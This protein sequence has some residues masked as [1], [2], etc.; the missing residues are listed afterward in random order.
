M[1][2]LQREQNLFGQG[3]SYE[4]FSTL[5]NRFPP[6]VQ[7]WARLGLQ[8]EYR[9]RSREVERLRKIPRY[10]RTNTDL[11]GARLEIPDAASFLVLHEDLIVREAYRFNATGTE[12][13]IIDGGANIGV[14]TIYFK[15]AHPKS[16]I[17]AFEPDP[18]IFQILD[19]NCRA[20]GL[21]GVELVQKALW[22]SEGS[23]DF[24][25]EGSDAGR[26]SRKSDI[27]EIISVPACRLR[28]YLNEEVEMLKLDIEGAETAVLQDC[29][30]LL[31]NVHHLFVEYHS[32]VDSPQTLT[33][34]FGLLR[35]AGFRVHVQSPM[36]SLQPFFRREA[37]L[38][39]DLQLNIFAFRTSHT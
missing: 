10:T 16:R 4:A 34:I 11:L 20:F 36:S 33:M 35:D 29:A 9:W 39:M 31:S 28:P 15:K 22:A 13:L 18:E 37:Y 38:G 21:R 26:V 19:E 5:L 1:T 23:L 27:G 24:K 30:D 14:S 6:R 7:H 17:I 3:F 2:I 12:P 8:R 32:F 25:R